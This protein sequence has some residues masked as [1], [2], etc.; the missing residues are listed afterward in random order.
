MGS[1]NVV[2]TFPGSGTY[3]PNAAAQTVTD[4]VRSFCNIRFGLMVGVGGGAPK[5]PD[6][7]DTRMDIRLGDVVVSSPKGNHGGVLYYD[8]GKQKDDGRFD[9]DSHLNKPPKILLKAIEILQSDHDFGEG[10]MND[11]I[12]DVAKR[13][14][15][16]PALRKYR[17]PGRDTDQLFR[18]SYCHIAGEDCAA[19]DHAQVENRVERDFDEP[20]VHYGLIASGHAVMRSAQR[21]DEL[22]DAWNVSC[23]EMEAAGLMDDFPYW[24]APSTYTE[25]HLD[26]I[27]QQQH[28]TGKWF[29]ESTE[30]KAWVE[31]TS[32]TLFCP[33]IP[34]AGK[35]VLASL[36]I[37]NLSKLTQDG[38]TH[39]LYLY[40]NYRRQEDQTVEKLVSALLRQLVEQSDAIPESVDVLYNSHA[41]KIT[42]PSPKEVF[43]ALLTIAGSLD[44]IFIV[45]DAL[46]E[47]KT[48]T[49][50]ELLARIEELKRKATISLLATSRP[51]DEI[52]HHFKGATQLTIKANK[53][54][55]EKFIDSQ[56]V[57]LP[58][59]IRSSS[60]LQ[61]KIR[62]RI[63]GTVEGMFLLA[64]LNLNSLAEKMT[65]LEVEEALEDMEKHPADLTMAYND[66]LNR[67]E[68]QVEGHRNWAY[69]ILSWLLYARM[70]LRSVELQYAL[71]IRAGDRRIEQRNLPNIRE[72]ISLCAGLVTLN[73]ESQI[74]Q[75]VHYT[76][77]QFFK[78]MKQPPEWIY[79]A[80]RHIATTCV[81]YLSFDAFGTGF[82]SADAEFEDR[83]QSNILYEYAARNWGHHAYA[84][85]EPDETPIIGFLESE[86]HVSA[87]S[88]AMMASAV[89]LGYSQKVARNV[90]GLHLVASFGLTKLI[91]TLLKNGH[92]PRITDSCGHTALSY[93]ALNGHHSVV[94]LL[95]GDERVDPDSKATGY[96]IGRT[97]SGR[98]ALMLAAAKGHHKVAKLLLAK[99]GVDPDS[100]ATDYIDDGRTAL[101]FAAMNGHETVVKQLLSKDGVD[102][103]SKATGH[104]KGRSP[105][106]FAAEEGHE[107]VVKLLVATDGVDPNSKATR[108]GE[109]SGRS[110]LSFA[111]AN[112]HTSVVEL[113][114]LKNIDLDSQSSSGRTA[115][116]YAA[117][118][119]HEDVVRLLLSKDGV[120]PDS[121]ATG[122]KDQGRT[123]LSFAAAAGHANIVNLL[124]SKGASPTS[125]N[126]N[127]QTPLTYA[128]MGG[129]EEVVKVLLADSRVEPDY[130]ATGYYNGRTPLSLAAEEGHEVVVKLL[131]DK[132][133]V[134]PDSVNDAARTPLSY[135]A[136]NGH[137]AVVK[138]LLS[139]NMA[140]PDSRDSN[141][142]TPLSFAAGNGH[143]GVVRLLL[144]N[145]E[146][147]P[148][149]KA[150]G[151]YSKRTPLSLAS[152]EGHEEVVRLLLGKEEVDADSMSYK[153]QSPLAYASEGGHKTIVKLLLAKD[154]V[155]PDSLNYSNQTPLSLAAANGHEAVVKMLLDTKKVDPDSK[156]SNGRTPLSF[157]AEKGHE[158]VTK[159]LLA[160]RKVNLSAKDSNGQSPLSLATVY[161]HWAV[162]KFLQSHEKLEEADTQPISF[163]RTTSL[164]TLVE[165]SLSCE[166]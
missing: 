72:V 22:R 50:A 69:R 162:V 110:P 153:K 58:H 88:Q 87:S 66:A 91:T 92:D 95:L 81:V 135:A 83:L 46:D 115:L 112:G 54:D 132:N 5:P 131:L 37:K 34:G 47:C 56:L 23:F 159:L 111:S 44:R 27:E 128:A 151:Y 15:K 85:L 144:E 152:E 164:D 65:E 120:N 38:Q 76:T 143:K 106:S 33:G 40:C 133:G 19:C 20:V 100:K 68:N 7:D 160:T 12:E 161:G 116:S 102:P 63:S 140:D 75:L 77:Q 166:E 134:D 60:A 90:V 18:A 123:P 154:S 138:L 74:V 62:M 107:E 146:V 141:K 122:F 42:R 136:A 29:L 24:I 108:H 6:P 117:Q 51:V 36:A 14:L 67:I 13:S 99:E 125:V 17:F 41:G 55:V 2:I 109:D 118:A 114:L 11:Y 4:M 157:A 48:K 80:Q 59:C 86:A 165:D 57:Q 53:E 35:T 79:E 149:S 139:D 156:A 97:Y 82:C 32:D 71:A 148:D 78:S 52:V 21:R 10:N 145:D 155:N 73:Q 129:H 49:R 94:K 150:T 30:F 158:A 119:G 9:I 93:A 121:V 26:I 127:Q 101:S 104:Y 43:N 45:I 124:L 96:Q 137:E 31:G 1:H 16:L 89:S 70:P 28:G 113:L 147:D 8:M 142:R 84:A 98:T 105:L 130:E 126:D 103:D 64:K 39:V 3:G 61:E 163:S 25:Q